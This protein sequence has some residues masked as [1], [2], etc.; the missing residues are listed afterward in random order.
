VGVRASFVELV[1]LPYKDE[2]VIKDTSTANDHSRTEY[3]SFILIAD[4]YDMFT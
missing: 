2:I 4:E 1:M 3:V